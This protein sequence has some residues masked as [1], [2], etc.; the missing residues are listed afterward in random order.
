MITKEIYQHEN[1]FGYK[2]L[3]DGQ[4]VIVQPFK[5]AVQGNQPMTEAQ[6]NALADMVIAKLNNKRTESEE[7]EY[8]TLMSKIIQPDGT[9]DESALT[10]EELSR[11]RELANKGHPALTVEEVN[12]V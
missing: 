11:L 6:A 4:P 1:G 12:S 9:I 3:I 7:T 8:Q 5:P 10:L 2:I